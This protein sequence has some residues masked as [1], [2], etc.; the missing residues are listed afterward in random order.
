MRRGGLFTTGEKPEEREE[1]RDRKAAWTDK[2]ESRR[3][4]CRE[5]RLQK[6]GV[7]GLPDHPPRPQGPVEPPEVEGFQSSELRGPSAGRTWYCGSQSPVRILLRPRTGVPAGLLQEATPL[8]L[9]PDHKQ[10]L[11]ELLGHS[12]A[13]P[14]AP[15]SAYLSQHSSSL[16]IPALPAWA[17]SGVGGYLGHLGVALGPAMGS[18][19]QATQVRGPNQ[20][21]GSTGFVGRQT[22]F[23]GQLCGLCTS[24]FCVVSR[25]H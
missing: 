7:A 22:L 12:W 15:T 17:G 23:S 18:A 10:G 25:N 14:R 3:S 1:A 8:P 16:P 11:P 2:L 9:P 13:S 24:V 19:P 5:E 20:T 4:Q 21:E 6:S